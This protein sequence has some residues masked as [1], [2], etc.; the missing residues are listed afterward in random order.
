M[1]VNGS[2]ILSTYG[3]KLLS[4]DIQPAEITVYDDWLRKGLSPLYLGKQEKFKK[5]KM[6]FLISGATDNT[7]V[8]Y[9]SNFLTQLKVAVIKF[10]DLDHYYSCTLASCDS[11]RLIQPGY[12]LLNVEMHSGYGYTSEVTLTMDHVASLSP[13]IQGNLPAAVKLT[14]TTDGALAS[15]TIGGFASSIIIKNLSAGVPVVID[16]E[17][18]LVTQNG[19][20]KFADLE[21]WDFPFL[22]P[23]ANTI[24]LNNTACVMTIKY[25]P[26]FL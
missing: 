3:A 18:C 14:I 15:L 25:K 17:T 24:T 19:S 5:I 4:K 7:C 1:L 10:D 16:G 9:I 2:D 23:G 11:A 6:Q 20:N 21:T 13:T 12:F 26:K 8:A 22:Q